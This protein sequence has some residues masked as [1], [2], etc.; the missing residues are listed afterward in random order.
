MTCPVMTQV[1]DLRSL[2]YLTHHQATVTVEGPS[3]VYEPRAE[4]PHPASLGT[5]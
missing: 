3:E 1:C 2:S 5:L 4:Q